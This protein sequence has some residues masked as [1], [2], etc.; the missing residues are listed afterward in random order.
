MVGTDPNTV[1]APRDRLP[2]GVAVIHDDGDWSLAAAIWREEE[3]GNE[4]PAILIRWNGSDLRPGGHPFAR[5]PVWF[6]LPR[7]VAILA[8]GVIDSG[9]RFH[10]EEWLHGNNQP[11]VPKS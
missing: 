1:V 10:V 3:D 11:F 4:A 7:P 8:L 2:H 6:V 5:R 9:L